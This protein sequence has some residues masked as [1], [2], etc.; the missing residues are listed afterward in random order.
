MKSV[1]SEYG[2]LK[3][4]VICL[5]Y[6]ADHELA[7]MENGNRL[8]KKIFDKPSIPYSWAYGLGM[9]SCNSQ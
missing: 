9:V 8:V 4:E 6:K 3:S 7:G 5:K 2:E 1:L